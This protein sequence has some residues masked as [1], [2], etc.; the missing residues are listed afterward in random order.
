MD[1]LDKLVTCAICLEKYKKPKQLNRQHVFCLKPCLT[2]LL[3]NLTIEC[4]MCRFKHQFKL[5]ENLNCL[6]NALKTIDLL[7]LIC[8]N[9]DCFELRPSSEEKICFKCKPFKKIDEI[10]LV[11]D[12]LYQKFKQQKSKNVFLFKFIIN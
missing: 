11:K 7:E 1:K 8:Y 9:T 10:A 6:P 2:S 5:N 4:P 3:K 12:E